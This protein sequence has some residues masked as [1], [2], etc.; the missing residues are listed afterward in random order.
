MKISQIAAKAAVRVFLV[1]LVA[2]TIPFCEIT[3]I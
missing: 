3:A 1:L 2:A